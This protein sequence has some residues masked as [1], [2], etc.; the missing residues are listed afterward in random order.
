MLVEKT[1]ARLVSRFF[2]ILHAGQLHDLG[3]NLH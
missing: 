2:V 1:P 3:R